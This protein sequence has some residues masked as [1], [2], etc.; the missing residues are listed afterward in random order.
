MFDKAKGGVTWVSSLFAYICEIITY[1]LDETEMLMDWNSKGGWLV[2]K[3]RVLWYWT[4]KLIVKRCQAWRNARWYGK[5]GQAAAYTVFLFVLY[6]LMVD[7]NFLWL[8][9]GSPTWSDIKEPATNVASEVYSADGKLLGKYFRENRT[10]VSYEEINPMLI[11][12]LVVTED[13]RFYSHHGI[14]LFGM[15]SAIKDMVVNEKA[16]GGSTITQQLVKNMFKTRSSYSRGLIGR[17]PG[18]NIIIAKTKEWITAVKIEFY[19]RWKYRRASE[20]GVAAKRDIVTAYLNTVDFG[21]NAFGIKTAAKTYFGVS[22]KDLKVEECATLVGMLKATTTYNPKLNPKNSM[23]RRNVVLDNLYSHDIITKSECDSLQKI[24]I[25]L[26]R[27]KVAQN[28][29]GNALYVRQAIADDLESFLEEN[30]YDLY[31]GGLKIYT[32]ID[33]KMQLYAEE[34]VRER[35]EA[36]QGMFDRHWGTIGEPARWGRGAEPWRDERGVIIDDFI[37]QIVRGSGKYISLK[38]KMS[39]QWGNGDTL[40]SLILDSLNRDLHPVKVFDYKVGYKNITMTTVDSV[41]YMQR[42]LHA[43]FIAMDAKTGFVKA[44]VGD[45]DFRFWKYDKVRAMRQPGSTFK[46]FDYTAAF[47]QGWGPCSDSVTDDYVM[48]KYMEKGEEKRWT[49]HNADGVFTGVPMT[50]KCAFARSIN[51]VAVKVSEKV[52]IKRIIETA[53]RMGIESQI[54]TIPSVCLGSQDLYLQEL[55]NAYCTIVNEGNMQSP[56]FVTRIEDQSGDEIYNYKDHQKKVND[57]VTYETSFLMVQMLRA[58]LTEPDATSM[59]LWSWIGGLDTDFGGKTGTSN[60][61]SDAWYVG[62]TPSLVAG[63]WVGGEHRCVHFRTGKLGSGSKLALPI[64]GSWFR[65]TLDDASFS[66]YKGRFGAPKREIRR[67]YSC[68]TPY[69]PV[70]EV[71]TLAG[72]NVTEMEVEL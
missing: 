44:Y 13:E 41:K 36:I 28:Y 42:F 24:L 49:P 72:D 62:V 39:G 70:E 9:G 25:D 1:R 58:G 52:G 50:L 8:F 10:P 18:V 51:S 59:A 55:V 21:S 12:T 64:V 31:G 37:P 16:R 22:P 4:K 65:K 7:V 38:K 32:T 56:V 2:C 61:H 71:D 33:S 57:A 29:E 26:T 19:Y 6:L 69:E 40:D 15:G 47:E 68:Q 67:S 63:A 3:L 60:N 11:K 46:L 35:M 14:D 17:I 66:N 45:V 27:Y 53:H 48:I 30:G 34:A 54:D 5:V 23:I 43:G 20:P